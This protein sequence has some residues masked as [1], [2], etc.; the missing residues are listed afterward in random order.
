[1]ALSL[2]SPSRR[3]LF[4]EQSL[5]HAPASPQPTAR[6]AV[7]LAKSESG[8]QIL[9]PTYKD[10]SPR[11]RSKGMVGCF[12]V[13]QYRMCVPNDSFLQKPR[14]SIL[15]TSTSVRN[16]GGDENEDFTLNYGMFA[17]RSEDDTMDTMG[18][19]RRVS[20]A[21]NMAVRWFE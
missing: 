20:F 16:E 10:L 3:R 21:R 6:N 15:K 2:P 8:K 1:M 13:H 4:G 17:K 12:F 5:N 9:A 7:Q 18:L 11:S 14:K 19:P